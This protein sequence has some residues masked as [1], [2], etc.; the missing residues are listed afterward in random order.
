MGKPGVMLY[1]DMRE[2]LMLLSREERGDL[3]EAILNYGE[4]G[5]VP[6]FDGKL[7]IAW[8]FV[9]DAIDRDTQRY[10][11][12]VKRNEYARFVRNQYK[13]GEQ[14]APYEVWLQEQHAKGDPDVSAY[15]DLDS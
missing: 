11:R 1:F 2:G 6:E 9:K 4:F 10:E 3:F 13:N 14:K 12:V 8:C 15:G 5:E 7:G